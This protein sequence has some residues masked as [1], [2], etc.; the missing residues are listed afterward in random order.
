MG[1]LAIPRAYSIAAGNRS[2]CARIGVRLDGKDMGHT[3]YAYDS[4]EG[5]VRLAD[6]TVIKGRVEPYWRERAPA[7][8]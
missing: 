5:W 2:L 6:G 7:H 1:A 8:S 4:V 3:I